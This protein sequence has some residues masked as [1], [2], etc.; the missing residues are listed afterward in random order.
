MLPKHG[1]PALFVTRFLFLVVE[2]L[3]LSNTVDGRNLFHT[4]LKPSLKPLLV[5]IF[6]G[7]ESE[8]GVSERW[9]AMD[10][11]TIH[12]RA[13]TNTHFDYEL[14]WFL[15]GPACN[16]SR[17]SPSLDPDPN[18]FSLLFGAHLSS[19]GEQHPDSPNQRTVK[20]LP[21]H[22]GWLVPLV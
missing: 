3:G 18:S 14:V 7:I 13:K 6:Q 15:V 17:G 2:M 20:L 8:T 5:G 16:P 10:F 22:R 21:E 12:S 4:T 1:H 19:S 9:W 11:A